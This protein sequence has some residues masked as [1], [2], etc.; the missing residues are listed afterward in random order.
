MKAGRARMMEDLQGYKVKK[1]ALRE[2][3]LHLVAFPP[4][5]GSGVS[6]DDEALWGLMNKMDFNG[7]KV[8]EGQDMKWPSDWCNAVRSFYRFTFD[9]IEEHQDT[10]GVYRGVIGDGVHRYTSTRLAIDNPRKV[11]SEAVQSRFQ[12]RL[13]EPHEGVVMHKPKRHTV[14]DPFTRLQ[15]PVDTGQQER[16][17]EEKARKQAHRQEQVDRVVKAT[18]VGVQHAREGVGRAA[19]WFKRA[20]QQDTWSP[21]DESK[22][23]GPVLQEAGEER[24]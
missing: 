15:K 13:E 2:Y 3:A 19:G 23:E 18:V 21:T 7:V 17:A 10:A 4:R 14:M 5:I 24:D 1:G 22:E 9:E 16:E 12:G 6:K 8:L 11:R 20:M